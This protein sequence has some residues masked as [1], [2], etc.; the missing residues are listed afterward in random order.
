[1]TATNKH[2]YDAVLEDWAV[3]PQTNRLAGRVY[4]DEQSRF[5]DGE[6]VSTSTLKPGASLVEGNIVETRNTR[7]LLGQR[8]RQTFR[9]GAE[10]V[11]T[12]ETQLASLQA[13]M[14]GL[15]YVIVYTDNSVFF[16][17]V[18]GEG[19]NFSFANAVR[20]HNGF[21]SPFKLVEKVKLQ[22]SNNR[23]VVQSHKVH[24]LNKDV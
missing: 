1:M 3:L 19:G 16:R 4:G 20:Y 18:N 13:F 23:I 8:Y 22:R 5:L 24:Y 12:R 21:N 11:N 2:R 9:D 10:V 17:N 14:K 6:A 15:G 7:Y